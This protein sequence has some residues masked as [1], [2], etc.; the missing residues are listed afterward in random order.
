M[1]YGRRAARV[2]L[3]VNTGVEQRGRSMSSRRTHTLSLITVL[4]SA[5]LADAATINVPADEPT[6]N[7]AI[8][9]ASVGD[10]I[11]V[12]PGTYTLTVQLSKAVTVRSTDGPAVTVIVDC[13]VQKVLDAVCAIR[14]R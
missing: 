13:S 11:L 12:Q 1:A 3:S 14:G 8:D 4:V 5:G 10:L 7:A 9:A 2:S 6:I